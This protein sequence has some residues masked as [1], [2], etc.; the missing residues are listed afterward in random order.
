[1]R[2]DLRTDLVSFPA[3][4][5]D[6]LLYYL[7]DLQLGSPDDVLTADLYGRLLRNIPG[8]NGTDCLARL[9][10]LHYDVP[11]ALLGQIQCRAEMLGMYRQALYPILSKTK[12]ITEIYRFF[13]P[14]L[15]SV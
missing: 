7:P 3:S 11:G 14:C 1:M 9:G 5:E 10:A 13:T 4:Y 8:C 2:S 6:P 12:K 15:F